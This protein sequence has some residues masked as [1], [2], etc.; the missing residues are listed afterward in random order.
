M[1]PLLLLI[2]VSATAAA[3]PPGLTA[4]LAAARAATATRAGFAY[5]TAM[6]P[7]VH[8]A[9]VPC[10][11]PGRDPARGG[12]FTL[13]ADVDPTG[14]LLDVE[15]RPASP[16]AR[17]FAARFGAMRLRPPPASPSGRWPIAVEMLTRP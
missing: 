6:A 11:P 1:K 3:S 9:L 10:V 16:L 8:H 13:V 2:A 5:D 17:C 4:R 7:A 14:N 15:V 12:E